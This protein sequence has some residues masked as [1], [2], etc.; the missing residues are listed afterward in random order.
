MKKRKELKI[1]L[2]FFFNS[3]RELSSL[4]LC[5]FLIYVA[6]CETLKVGKRQ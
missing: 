3:D 4:E 1:I 5:A 2:T 6:A